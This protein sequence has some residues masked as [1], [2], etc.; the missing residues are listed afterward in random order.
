M[1]RTHHLPS[2]A[3]L[4]RS[5]PLSA[6]A[7]LKITL[8]ALFAACAITPVF[9]QPTQ[10]QQALPF[11]ADSRAQFRSAVPPRLL[12][13]VVDLRSRSFLP[14]RAVTPTFTS[15]KADLYVQFAHELT[16]EERGSLIRTG[17]RF[18]ESIGPTTYLVRAQ[19]AAFDALQGSPSVRGWDVVL[20]EDK[21]TAQIHAGE[22]G[23][24][25]LNPDGSYQMRVQFYEDVRLPEALYALD[26][27]GILVPDRS[28]FAI[29]HK[30]EVAGLLHKIVTLARST[31]VQAIEPT[32]RPAN[33]DNV[34]AAAL[35][36]INDVQVSP[37]NLNGDGIIFGQ[38][39]S[40]NARVDHADLIGRST[41]IG[42]SS[43]SDHATHV[44]G[45]II[46]SGAGDAT[47]RGMSPAAGL[48]S[49]RNGGNV[50]NDHANSLS[51]DSIDITNNSWS[52]TVGWENGVQTGNLGDFGGY[53][54]EAADFDTVVRNTG[55]VICKSAGNEGSD[56]DPNAP[57]DCDGILGSD[58]HRYR[59]VAT[60]G[61]AKNII[62]VGAVDDAG[63]IANFSSA[64]PALDTRIKPDVVAN[65]IGL[66][67][68][69][70]QGVTNANCGTGT[71]YCSNSGTSMS[72]PT[73]AGA[74]GLLF[75]RYRQ[76]YFGLDPS[77][78]IIKALIVNTAIDAGRPGP[79]YLY[80]HG[81]LDALRAVQTIDSGPVR[82]VTDAIDA[83]QIDTWL[84]A[85]PPGTPELRTT[86]C[87]IDPAGTPN[88]SS[89]DVK[90][91]LHLELISPTNQLFY[92]FTGSGLTEP[93]LTQYPNFRDTVKHGRITNPAQGF[94]RARVVSYEVPQGPQN[95]ALVS[96]LPF[97]LGTQPN[98]TVN[99]ALNYDEICE[100]EFQD[101][102]VSIFN[103]GG[104]DLL[105][106]SVTSA[107]PSV[108]IVQPNPI[109][110]FL[111]HP[112]SHVDVTVRFDPNI[113]GA[114]ILSLLRIFSND[115]DLGL[116]E[117]GM[118]GSSCPP[119]DIAISGSTTF[120][121]VCAGELSEKIL[122]ICN[123]GGDDLN[124]T[125]VAF[126]AGCN[127]FVMVNNI[128]PATV[129]P[130]HCLPLTVRY[131][132]TEAGPHT[133]T[134]R[135]WSNDPNES[136]LTV[137]YTGTTPGV[138]LDVQDVAAFDPTVLVSID[139]DCET[140]Q[141]LNITNNGACPIYIKDVMITPP[142]AHFGNFV[143]A[144][145]PAL[146]ITLNP[147]EALG[148]GILAVHFRPGQVERAIV[149][150]LKVVYQSDTPMLGD[151]TMITRTF[152]GEGVKT[153]ARLVLKRN[154]VA[155][156]LADRITLY[157]IES[158]GPPLSL[159][160]IESVTNKPL[161]NVPATPPCP[162]FSFHRE[163]GGITNPI[164]LP[165]G[166]YLIEARATINGSQEIYK[167]NFTVGVCDFLPDLVINFL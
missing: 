104:A 66:W 125:A 103:T 29:N 134:F 41:I 145:R 118:S 2:G 13:L 19:R 94:W 42:S 166:D 137:V 160:S 6:P 80:G 108:F 139:D 82:I 78:D 136:P 5:P 146:P 155:L 10:G 1:S 15:D 38:W 65:G 127:D 153:G 26:A 164:Q 144:N 37:Y 40:G 22:L 68:T 49:R 79:D 129:L 73:V 121:N 61:N 162:A 75:Q 149:G 106:H 36:N 92:P 107:F 46:G 120:G 93:A 148:D 11:D 84:I 90:N 9:A 99:A 51:M 23:S 140:W 87:W 4:Q 20:P 64:G 112:G 131:T 74:I 57:T 59:N 167:L 163:W 58:G 34:T 27:L 28:G 117:I 8:S 89:S 96:N 128:F 86:L 101:K 156:P 7:T 111:V 71:D 123:V 21:L 154:G 55:L 52:R 3:A 18:F 88:S 142:G 91:I 95:Y 122:N 32:P 76:V 105:V 135:I 133:C 24:H 16:S 70:A 81:I 119:P 100:G 48:L 141:P 72:T 161:I 152:C 114:S 53:D 157:K 30:I 126:L 17:V 63:L 165:P 39:E 25:A 116:Y 62:T 67:S 158:L 159:T 35:S 138:S 60:W 44:A 110:P 113:A 150:T 97:Q 33:D 54:G 151:D 31:A 109:Q 45:T 12:P 43:I 143:L 98:I 130:G 132:P 147:G 124:V 47:A 85:V 102:V 69:W 115:P 50:A 83:T 77:P 56:C 14:S